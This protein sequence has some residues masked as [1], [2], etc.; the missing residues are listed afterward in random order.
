MDFIIHSNETYLFDLYYDDNC[1]SLLANAMLFPFVHPSVNSPE[2]KK[3]K[4]LR[5]GERKEKKTFQNDVYLR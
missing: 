3:R 2:M 4:S 1:F 5:E